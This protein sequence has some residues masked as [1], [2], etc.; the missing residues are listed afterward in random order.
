MYFYYMYILYVLSCILEFRVIS[1]IFDTYF[2]EEISGKLLQN[3]H[4]VS[5]NEI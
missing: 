4:F 2:F 5:R 1:V 3:H